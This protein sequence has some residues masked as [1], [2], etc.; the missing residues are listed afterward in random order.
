MPDGP[1]VAQLCSL[2]GGPLSVTAVSLWETRR[3]RTRH[4]VVLRG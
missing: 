1:M 3:M 2:F 4:G